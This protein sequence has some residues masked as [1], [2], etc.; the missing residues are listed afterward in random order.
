MDIKITQSKISSVEPSTD[1]SS[2][3]CSINTLRSSNNSGTSHIMWLF[4]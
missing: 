1:V 2:S 3:L 4:C